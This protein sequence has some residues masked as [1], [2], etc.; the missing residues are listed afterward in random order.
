MKKSL[1]TKSFLGYLLR[2]RL[3]KIFYIKTSLS[4]N[5]MNRNNTCKR[6]FSNF[7]SRLSSIT[8]TVHEPH[9]RLRYYEIDKYINLFNLKRVLE[10]GTGRTTFL[11]NSIPG[12]QVISM[13]Q[14]INWKE[15]INPLFLE[16]GIS[17]DIR[18]CDVETYKEGCRVDD[19]PN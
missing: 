3:I 12:I 16:S 4:R 9:H 19:L 5:P 14:D 2:K 6:Y 7:N 13:E 15:I 8:N 17:P 10:I 11:F 1:Q 18:V